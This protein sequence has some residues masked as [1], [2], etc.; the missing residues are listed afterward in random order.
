MTRKLTQTG[1]ERRD[2][3]LWIDDVPLAQIADRVGTPT[4][5]YSETAV[6]ERF[7]TMR[8]AFAEA[9]ADSPKAMICY[10]VKANSNPSIVK[11]LATEGAGADLV[12]VGELHLARRT[13]LKPDKLVFSGVG[14]RRDELEQAIAANVQI[15]VESATEVAIIQEIAGRIRR[16][17][18]ILFRVNPDI[19]VATHVKISTGS[20]R[21]KF[22][23]DRQTLAE[24]CRRLV[25]VEEVRVDGLAVH[26]GSQIDDVAPLNQAL[27]SMAPAYQALRELGFNPTILD[28]GGGLGVNYGGGEPPD[29]AAWARVTAAHARALGVRLQVEPGRSLV[30]PAGFLMTRVMYVKPHYGRQWL[31]LDAA[32]NDLIRPALYGARH[33]FLPV[34]VE[35]VKAVP[36]V[37]AGPVCESSDVLLS[38]EEVLPEMQANDLGIFLDA[39]AYGAVM[40]ST[41]NMRPLAAEVL[42]R[43]D[44]WATVRSR[45]DAADL[46]G[47][48][49]MAP[50]LGSA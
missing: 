36:Y 8:L 21:H 18:R 11:A 33:R 47:P 38:E 44:A 40:G 26:L 46:L 13:G 42:V 28:A 3:E 2:G 25:D 16:R 10:A 20:S 15:N 23:I 48:E 39:G 41:Y 14:K 19:E 1:L 7:Q 12:S 17:A 32:M 45:K 31:I 5:V 43:G 24:L 29:L 49:A 27:K 4:Y 22:G 35:R 37:L 34:G 30:A 9:T 50:W 6:R